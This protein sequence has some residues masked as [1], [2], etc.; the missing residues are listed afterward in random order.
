MTRRDLILLFGLFQEN[1]YEVWQTECD[2][3][4]L[5]NGTGIATYDNYYKLRPDTGNTGNCH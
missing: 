1:Y 4:L 3:K 5:Q 2:N